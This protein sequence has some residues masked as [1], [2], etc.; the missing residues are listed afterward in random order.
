MPATRLPLG[1]QASLCCLFLIKSLVPG[2]QKEGKDIRVCAKEVEACAGLRAA[3][4][5]CKR[6]QIDARNRIVGNRYQ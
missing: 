6:G 5:Q 4:F 2:A 3:Y 1:R